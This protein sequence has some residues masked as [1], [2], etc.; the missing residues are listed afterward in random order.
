M[1]SRAWEAQV[2]PGAEG[3]HLVQAYPEEA[4]VKQNLSVAD[5][6]GPGT[7]FQAEGTGSMETGS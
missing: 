1:P 4:V 3:A 6:T 7:V 2:V 5:S